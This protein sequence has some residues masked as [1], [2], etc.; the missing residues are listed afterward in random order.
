[1]FE[2]IYASGEDEVA[3]V[4]KAPGADDVSGDYNEYAETESVD[5]DGVSVTMKGEGG[6]VS[7]AVWTTGD[8]SYA[9]SVEAAISQSDMA[10]R[11]ADELNDELAAENRD[12]L[13]FVWQAVRDLPEKYRAP[14]HLFYYEGYSTRQIAEILRRSEATVRSDLHRGRSLLR[15]ILKEAYDFDEIR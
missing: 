1:M 9:L 7:L 15:E 13:S 3:R 10:V 12:D 5:V 14:V 2:I 8:Y 11:A 6:L 4:R